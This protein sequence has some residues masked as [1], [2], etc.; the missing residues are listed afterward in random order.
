M[1]IFTNFNLKKYLVPF[2][3]S[4]PRS[5]SERF[6]LP[7]N[8]LPYVCLVCS[9]PN[10][11]KSFISVLNC[12]FYFHKLW[13]FLLILIWK[14]ILFLLLAVVQGQFQKDFYSQNLLPYVCL[15]C[16]DPDMTKSYAKWQVDHGVKNKKIKFFKVS[17]CPKMVHDL[18]KWQVNLYPIN[19]V[20][21]S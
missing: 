18:E 19:H 5:I 17:K 21:M 1:V 8:L 16:S 15:V 12:T 4:S 11:P 7:Q 10:M 13:S 20:Q 6:L 2:I 9:E 3:S 14:N